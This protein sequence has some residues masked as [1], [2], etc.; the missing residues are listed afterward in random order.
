MST[1]ANKQVCRLTV[2][3]P[4]ESDEV[5]IEVKRKIA[6]VVS[7]LPDS[8]INFGLMSM[9]SRPLMPPKPPDG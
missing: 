4:V 1:T 5:A 6:E 2:V 3:F 8:Q 7:E 9:P